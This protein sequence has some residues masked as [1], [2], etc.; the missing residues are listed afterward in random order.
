MC[1]TLRRMGHVLERAPLNIAGQLRSRNS[2]FGHELSASSESAEPEVQPTP[3]FPAWGSSAHDGTDPWQI[4]GSDPW[5][6]AS[7][8]SGTAAAAFP[9]MPPSADYDSGTDSDTRSSDGEYEFDDS[10]HSG[11][12]PRTSGRTN[13][14]ELPAGQEPLASPHRQ[15]RPTSPKVPEAEGKGKGFRGGKSKGKGKY[16]YSFLAEMSEPELDEIFFGRKGGGK[17]KS[18]STGKG[19]GRRRNPIGKDG[20]VMKCSICGSETHFRA[21]CPRNSGRPSGSAGPSGFSG[22]SETGPLGD[23]VSS[24]FMISSSGQQ[25]APRRPPRSASPGRPAAASM[26]VDAP[27]TPSEDPVFG[28]RDNSFGDAR[29]DTPS[30]G[31]SLGSSWQVPTSKALSQFLATSGMPSPPPPYPDTSRR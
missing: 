7:A 6:A 13:L 26:Q 31:S 28:P 19:K 16:R 3:V 30:V 9:T 10:D 5:S 14:L 4:P 2:Y 11:P 22:Y 12:D 23:I 15:T 17:G 8:S 20:Q 27:E 29:P 24:A 21:E 18:R 25:Q 1:L